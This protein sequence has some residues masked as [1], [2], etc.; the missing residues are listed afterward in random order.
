[1]S[2][3]A[4]S[5]VFV[6]DDLQSISRAIE[7]LQ[8]ITTEVDTINVSAAYQVLSE[9]DVVLVTSGGSDFTITLPYIDDSQ[10]KLYIV[11]KVDAAN[12]VTLQGSG[13]ETID[14]GTQTLTSQYQ[15]LR[16]MP[17]REIDKDT[18]IRGWHVV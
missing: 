13:S 8:Q 9:D 7:T 11:K 10:R 3:V 2:R 1:M 14:G 4:N 18:K 5:P 17:Q 6:G 16:L 12:T 15:V